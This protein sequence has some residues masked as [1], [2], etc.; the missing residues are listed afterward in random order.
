MKRRSD[1][2]ISASLYAFD[3]EVRSQYGCFAGVDEAGRG[4]LCG[5]V[6][7]AACI[8]DPENP[9]YGINDSKKLTE[10]KREALFDEICEKALAYRIVF[11]GPEVIDR[12]NILNATMGGMQQAVEELDIVPNLVLVDGNRT[13]AGLQIPAQPVVKGDATSASIG[14]ASVLAKVSRDRYMLE[15]VASPLTTGCAGT[16]S[17]AGVR[18]PSTRTRF[19]TMSSSSTACFMPPM[20][21]LRMLS[22]SMISGPTKTIL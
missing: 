21:A 12:E 13:P 8:L 9:V 10:K 17:P 15:L 3:A 7:V 2:E 20:V 22:R 6:C 18:F 16:S 19:G 1:E 14:A 4:P 5:P 11:V